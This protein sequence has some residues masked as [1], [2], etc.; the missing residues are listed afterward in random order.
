MEPLPGKRFILLQ[1]MVAQIPCKFRRLPFGRVDALEPGPYERKS[2]SILCDLEIFH[3]HLWGRKFNLR[4]IVVRR[5][6]ENEI[7]VVGD[8]G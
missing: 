1:H 7:R 4:W 3:P 2:H 5:S 8:A 6:G